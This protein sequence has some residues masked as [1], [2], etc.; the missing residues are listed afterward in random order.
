MLDLFLHAPRALDLVEIIHTKVGE[1]KVKRC[2]GSV[3]GDQI[4]GLNFM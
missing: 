1:L 3:R 2:Q 4:L